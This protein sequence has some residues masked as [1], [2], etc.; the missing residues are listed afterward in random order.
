VICDPNKL[1][2]KGCKGSPDLIIEILSPSTGKIDRWV[3]Y[4][5]YERAGVKEYWLVEPTNSTIE[6]FILNQ[7]GH[8]ELNG[9]FGKEDKV[10]VGLF[11]HL[12]IDLEI[13]FKE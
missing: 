9:V 1:D 7:D 3:K 13:I 11:D 12:I 10:T 4:K 2:D 8:F 6:V 5:L